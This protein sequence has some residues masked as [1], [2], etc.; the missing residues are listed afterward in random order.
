MKLLNFLKHGIVF[1]LIILLLVSVNKIN[2]QLSVKSGQA[3]VEQIENLFLEIVDS[4]PNNP[5]YSIELI[6]N[7][8][9]LALDLRDIKY[10][11]KVKT[12]ICQKQLLYRKIQALFEISQ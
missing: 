5:Q 6:K 12:A 9:S 4:M 8:D 7:A 10:V 11:K 2:A 1:P 3:M